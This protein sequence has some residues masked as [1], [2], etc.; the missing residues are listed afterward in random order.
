MTKTKT[1]IEKIK[2]LLALSESNNEHEAQRAAEMASRLLALHNLELTDLEKSEVTEETILE[3]GRLIHWERLLIVETAHFY[4]C[5]ALLQRGHRRSV[6]SLIG[7]PASV[8]T[9]RH[10]IDYFKGSVKR[11]LKEH[12][13]HCQIESNAQYC[14]GV[15]VRIGLRLQN[16]KEEL[17][18]NGFA[19]DTDIGAI[20]AIVIQ[21]QSEKEKANIEKFIQEKHYTATFKEPKI[22]DIEDPNF[23]L[24]FV[25]GVD[26]NLDR[27]IF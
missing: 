24:G 1:I 4:D 13:N 16:K 11:L 17:L 20:S 23:L 7:S 25:H 18:E 2:K 22:L 5:E 12:K 3:T 27:Q 6:L 15:A 9:S 19:A 14:Y 10:M 8:A 26:I 21:T